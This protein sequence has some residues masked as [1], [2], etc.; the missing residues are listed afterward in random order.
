MAITAT[1][2]SQK[3]KLNAAITAY[4]GG[5][6]YEAKAPIDGATSHDKTKNDPRAWIYKSL[7][8]SNIKFNGLD[9]IYQLDIPDYS[10][11]LAA[12]EKG[13]NLDT[14]GKYEDETKVAYE[15]IMG[16]LHNSGVQAFQADTPD[17]NSAID[18]FKQKIHLRSDAGM[19]GHDTTAYLITAVAYQQLEDLDNAQTYYEKLAELQY[20]DENVY[21]FLLR[22]YDEKQED[23]KYLAM[24]ETA[25]QKYPENQNYMLLEIDYYISNDRMDEVLDKMLAAAEENPQ[26]T[27]LNLNRSLFG[28]G[29]GYFNQAV[30]KQSDMD[31]LRAD[32]KTE[33][34]TFK[35]ERNALAEQSFPYFEKAMAADP[36]YAPTYKAMSE[37]YKIKG[38][39][40]KSNEFKAKYDSMTQ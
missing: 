11:A 31:F 33:Y 14:E 37:Y 1:V 19:E 28:V 34:E 16:G 36:D 12:L 6:Y 18:L 2:F 13:K 10:E 30:E 27:P 20:D 9:A 29:A 8:Y 15:V 35:K 23:E 5:K 24:L 4:D 39:L 7:I 40:A 3:G 38:D 22:Q 21:R 17:F 26:S 32:Q 25:K